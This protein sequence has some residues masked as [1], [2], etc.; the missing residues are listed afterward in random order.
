MQNFEKDL[1]NAL[2]SM[3]NAQPARLPDYFDQLKQTRCGTH[4]FLKQALQIWDIFD[5][6][7]ISG[8]INA[9]IK[10]RQC[11]ASRCAGCQQVRNGPSQRIATVGNVSVDYCCDKGLFFIIWALLCGLDRII[12]NQNFGAPHARQHD[13]YARGTSGI[14]GGAPYCGVDP[15][16]MMEYYESI[17]IY[18]PG[19]G[20]SKGT[21]YGGGGVM[22]AHKTAAALE[23]TPEDQKDMIIG[24]V[25]AVITPLLSSLR[26]SNAPLMWEA[27]QGS[28]VL[29]KVS[30]LLRNDDMKNVTQRHHLYQRVLN[31]VHT[32]AKSPLYSNVMLR[33]RRVK[34]AEATLYSIS[35]GKKAFKPRESSPPVIFYLKDLSTQAQ[36][37]LKAAQVAPGEYKSKEGQLQVSLCKQIVDLQRTLPPGLS[38]GQARAQPST[39]RAATYVPLAQ[40]HKDHRS[41]EIAD[42]V[43]NQIHCYWGKGMYWSGHV[44]G[45]MKKL[46]EQ[47]A[48]LMTSL[49]P[50]IFIRY[51]SSRPDMIKALIIGPA[52][53][54]YENGLFEFDILCPMNYP[55]GPPLVKL[56][57]TG[58]GR[59]SFNPNLYADGKGKEQLA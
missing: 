59:V 1:G 42:E 8:K 11:G 52:D 14:Y 7:K 29:D 41:E 28:T 13:V 20:K 55:N 32:L 47:V 34:E 24:D 27:F 9:A 44:P 56:R 18:G 40:Y 54:P 46:V 58:G 45:R 49:P 53:T 12:T 35:Q 30:E 3:G 39:N 51:A 22:A 2:P 16:D 21:G 25:L 26:G 31:F 10:C 15:M 33:D 17:G 36:V 38:I 19:V 50:G 23:N 43:M 4:S 48:N 5:K 6:W 57:T 37:I